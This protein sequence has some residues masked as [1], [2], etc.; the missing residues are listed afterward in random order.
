QWQGRAACSC[1]RGACQGQGAPRARSL[2]ARR[3]AGGR[4]HRGRRAHHQRVRTSRGRHRAGR[5]RARTG[6][7]HPGTTGTV[8]WRMTIKTTTLFRMLRVGERVSFDNGRIT[9]SL[10]D[11]SGRTAR[12]KL[13]LAQNVV[14]DKPRVAANDEPSNTQL[15]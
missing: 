13:T 12:L 2:A 14:V 3:D 6:E 11:K 4:A 8:S 15:E 9:L 1:T 5:P 10:E 7:A